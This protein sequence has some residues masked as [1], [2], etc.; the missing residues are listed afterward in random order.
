MKSVYKSNKNGVILPK[1]TLENGIFENNFAT[2]SIAFEKKNTKPA[3]GKLINF[4]T[5]PAA[6]NKSPPASVGAKSG[7]IT[8]VAIS[9]E[10]DTV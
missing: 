8:I 5:K 4:P 3:N 10:K 1:A 2:K 7:V 6:Q 9:E